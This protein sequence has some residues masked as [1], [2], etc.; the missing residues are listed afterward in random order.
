MRQSAPTAAAA[1]PRSR[2]RSNAISNGSRSANASGI[3]A[4]NGCGE[5]CASRYVG[6]GISG[7]NETQVQDAWHSASLSPPRPVRGDGGKRGKVLGRVLP[8]GHPGGG[9]VARFW[10]AN[11]PA[12]PAAPA[13]GM[14]RVCLEP[15]HPRDPR[16]PG[17]AWTGVAGMAGL[18]GRYRAAS[19]LWGA[20]RG[21][22]APAFRA[23]NSP[24]AP[25]PREPRRGVC[26]PGFRGR[27]IPAIPVTI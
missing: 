14:G 4:T 22:V 10:A 1:V 21:G 11:I 19:R 3:H 18:P 26:D 9:C 7:N 6:G 2:N 25:Q 20:P 8:G 23:P 16:S 27:H 24:A 15:H 12:S 13:W 5:R 17:G